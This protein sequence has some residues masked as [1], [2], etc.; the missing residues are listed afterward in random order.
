MKFQLKTKERI[1]QFNVLF[2][3]LKAFSEYVILNVSNEGIFMQ[4][5]DVSQTSC[6]ESKLTSEWFDGYEYNL[7]DDKVSIGVST[8]II[9][10]IL[11]IYYENQEIEISIDDNQDNLFVSF[12]GC[13]DVLDKY[14]EIPLMDI[15]QDML[16]ITNE[17]SE[18]D[19]IMESKQL[20][21]LVSQLHVFHDKLVLTFTET[22]VLFLASGQDGTMKVNVNL[23][24]F[25]EYAIQ[26]EYEL[27][28]AYNLRHISMMC[29]FGKLNKNCIMAFHQDRPMETRFKLDEESY[30]V[31]YLAPKIDE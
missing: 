6:F 21:N 25:V 19:I 15:E 9:Q 24:D 30:V 27:T 10:K 20:C 31:F 17:E 11:A 1:T 14:F 29:L 8:N 7:E 13:D 2:Q 12:N 3:N 23:N 5:M 18:I 28:Q 4:G 22:Q 16:D 26:E